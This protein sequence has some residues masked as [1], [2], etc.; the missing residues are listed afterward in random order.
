MS[1]I[2]IFCYRLTVDLGQYHDRSSNL[3][4]ARDDLVLAR[5]ELAV[6][7]RAHGANA[8]A[9]GRESDDECPIIALA[10]TQGPTMWTTHFSFAL[11][12]ISRKFGI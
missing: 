7:K 12:K 9:R 11:Q 8:Q 3:S 1:L 2:P 4:R 10:Q 6:L 5:G